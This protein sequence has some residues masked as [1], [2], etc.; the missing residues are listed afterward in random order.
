MKRIQG[1]TLSFALC[2]D[3]EGYEASLEVGKSYR[4]IADEEAASHGY[5]R[6][7]DE[8]GDDYAFS[9]RR[10]HPIELPMKVG[11]AIMAGA[12]K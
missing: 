11:K 5:V 7:I 4:V 1:K 10:F 8:S 3:N 12:R 6:V 9:A 2:L